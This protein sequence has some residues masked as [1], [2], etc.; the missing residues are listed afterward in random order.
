MYIFCAVFKLTLRDI[1]LAKHARK[2]SVSDAKYFDRGIRVGV[3]VTVQMKRAAGIIFRCNEREKGYAWPPV[4]NDT[5]YQGIERDP[6]LR[7]R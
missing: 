1:R 2:I 6:P 7:V 4:L 5:N 3:R